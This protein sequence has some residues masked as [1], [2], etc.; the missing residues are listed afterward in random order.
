MVKLA[1]VEQNRIWRQRFMAKADLHVHSVYSEHPSEWFLQRIGAAES[2]TE[3]EF[4]YREAKKQGM[5]FVAITDHNKIDGALKLKAKYPYD[6]IVGLE[7][8]AYFPE[9]RCKVH[10]LI[11]GLNQAQFDIIQEIRSNIYELR[12]YLLAENLPHSVAHATYSVNGKLNIE[13]LEK[14]ILLFD[15]FEGING[16]RNQM[17]NLAWMNV[18]KNIT[19]KHIQQLRQKYPNIELASQKPWEKSLTGGSDDH[20]GLF[21]GQTYTQAEGKTPETFLVNLKEKRSSTCG[22]HNNYQALAFTLYKIA[23]EFSRTKGSWLSKNLLSQLTEMI[24]EKKSLSFKNRIKLKHFTSRQDEVQ[25]RLRNAI[26]ELAEALKKDKEFIVGQ[27]IEWIYGKI[28]NLGDE[29]LKGVAFSIQKSL[30]QGNFFKLIRNI[31]SFLPG[32]FLM[33]PFFSTSG[34]MFSNRQLLMDIQKRFGCLPESNE[35]KILWFSDTID[36]LNGVSVTVSQVRKIAAQLDKKVHIV[37]ASPKLKGQDNFID[38]PIIYEFSLPYYEKQRIQIPSILR[39]LET[40]VEENPDE[41]IVSTPGPIGLLGVLAAKILHIP[42]SGIYHTD[43]TMQLESIQEDESFSGLVEG[44]VN[45]FYQ[46]LSRIY[47]PTNSY[48]QMLAEKGYDESKLVLFQR[49]LDTN[50][51]RFRSNGRRFL[52]EEYELPSGFCF[53]FAGRISRDKNPD[54]A[55]EAFKNIYENDP[56]TCLLMVGDGPYLANLKERYDSHPGI[57]FT[58]RIEREQLPLYYSGAGLFVFPSETDTFGMVVME[59]LACGLPALVT[60]KGG[61]KEIVEDGVTGRIISEQTVEAWQLHMEEMMNR[62]TTNPFEYERFRMRIF[63][64]AEPGNHWESLI[65]SLCAN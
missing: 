61:P 38:L 24:F 26:Q 17:N 36:D 48:K 31:S 3:P 63:E 44:F 8:T 20:A 2:Y 62:F 16:G 21:I 51:F 10:I 37:G 13:H 27:R 5:D 22:R 1:I 57:I 45:W 9:D 60:D 58:G 30:N 46:S 6:V 34:H 23:Y 25:Y 54:L 15:V 33:L 56:S 40:I 55:L 43:F 29:F 11:Y 18:L 12:D 52:E 14:L 49:G 65:D 7:A 47:V 32:A 4:I 64:S 19:P 35:K 42:C 39:S 59:A 28:A 50:L 41:I 53:L